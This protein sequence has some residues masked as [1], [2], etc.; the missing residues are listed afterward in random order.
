[1]QALRYDDAGQ[2]LY[3]SSD[4]RNPVL[5]SGEALIRILRA[6]I[7]STVRTFCFF[8]SY[9]NATVN[10]KH[11]S[12]PGTAYWKQSKLALLYRI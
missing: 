12:A 4:Q 1:M 7:C 6:G 3:L 2:G 9:D 8:G 10:V 5:Q 11:A